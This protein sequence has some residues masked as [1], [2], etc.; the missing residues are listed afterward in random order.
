MADHVTPRVN[1]AQHSKFVG[2]TV[3]VAGKVKKT[4][5]DQ[6]LVLE[7]SDGGEILAKM[8]MEHQVDT[9]FVELIGQVLEP[10]VLKVRAVIS[11]SDDMD[12]KILNYVAELWHDPKYESM[13]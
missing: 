3:R 6:T 9:A 12:T 2:R 4:N 13:F 5:H 7:C 10:G 1:F 11:L 8:S